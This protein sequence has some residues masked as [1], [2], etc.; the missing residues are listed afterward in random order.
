MRRS[1]VLWHAMLVLLLPG[2]R[3]AA[4]PLVAEGE[5]PRATVTGKVTG[6]L[7]SG[8]I[9]GRQVSAVDVTTGARYSTKTTV[10]GGY[11]LLVPPG[12]Y[13]LEVAL[14]WA[15]RVVGDPGTLELA[16][17]AF[18]READLVLGGAGLASEP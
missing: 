11:S 2:C 4:P 8:P 12:R 5:P 14:L 9:A 13:R 16:P 18:V 3:A 10:S 7:G 17:G 15:E 6:P 1:I